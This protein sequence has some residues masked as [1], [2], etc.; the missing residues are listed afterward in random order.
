MNKALLACVIWRVGWLVVA[1]QGNHYVESDT[2]HFMNRMESLMTHGNQGDMFKPP[3][4]PGLLAI[5]YQLLGLKQY[6]VLILQSLMD[7]GLCALL[8]NAVKKSTWACWAI[9][10]FFG[11]DLASTM[12]A[13]GIMSETSGTFFL[14]L[15]WFFTFVRRQTF[16]GG[17]FVA[18][19]ICFR[20]GNWPLSL[21]FIAIVAYQ[22][23]THLLRPTLAYILG[24]GLFLSPLFTYHKVHFDKWAL[25]DQTRQ[26]WTALGGGILWRQ[27]G[28]SWYEGEQN[29][30]K[31][32]DEVKQSL[33]PEQQ[34]QWTMRKTLFKYIA[35]NPKA[36]IWSS[37]RGFLTYL[38]GGQNS[39]LM[40]RL[41]GRQIAENPLPKSIH[42]GLIASHGL[43]MLT[44]WVL[45]FLSVFK[46]SMSPQTRVMA[47]VGFIVVAYFYVVAP[48]ISVPRYR[49]PVMPLVSYVIALGFSLKLLPTSLRHKT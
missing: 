37:T 4:Y 27:H 15:G 34:A 35:E 1:L 45:F 49:V 13:T 28:Y 25:T 19:S 24:L 48:T 32:H 41:Q 5:F 26:H 42:W 46:L 39:E 2:H 23:S 44:V 3:G 7:L 6:G 11:M 47:I 16:L 40:H 8:M 31:Y 21:L 10:L 36:F 43:W 22:N 9:A 38:L 30:A 18:L 14:T 20:A 17:V 12:Y 29:F 33:P